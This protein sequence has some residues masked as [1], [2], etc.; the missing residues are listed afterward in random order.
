MTKLPN[1]AIDRE[2][3]RAALFAISVLGILASS[4][5]VYPYDAGHYEGLILAPA[6]L[7]ASGTNPYSL[8]LAT[9][10]PYVVSGYGPVYYLVVGLGIRLF[11]PN[12]WF[13][14]LAA[15]AA[16]LGCIALVGVVAR[17][18]GASRRWAFTASALFA[19]TSPVQAWI[20]L[21]RPDFVALVA[22]LGGL[23]LTL[24]SSRNARPAIGLLAG[25]LLGV[26]LATRQT[27]VGPVVASGLLA[28]RFGGLRSL[29]WLASG[30]LIAGGIPLAMLDATSNGG[31]VAQMWSM[32]SSLPRSAIVFVHHL[33]SL[34]Q[35]PSVWTALAL[36]GL[37]TYR[38]VRSGGRLPTAA[39][40]GPVSLGWLASCASS[41]LTGSIPG[42]NV[43]YFLEPLALACTLA[44]LG[45][46][47]LEPESGRARLGTFVLLVV[48]SSAGFMGARSVRGEIFRWQARPYYDEL[49]AELRRVTPE[50]EAC[51]SLYP[52]LAVAANRRYYVNTMSGYEQSERLRGIL[53]DLF[54][55]RRFAALVWPSADPPTGYRPVRLLHAVPERFHAAH[56]HVRV[57][58][59]E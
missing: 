4:R 42:S 55:R 13:G 8:E 33:S 39:L 2:P 16:A 35:S 30:A 56:L 53:R 50:S 7:M 37:H 10:P 23:A 22:A 14:R 29:G 58:P 45:L 26:A 12:L 17:Q 49:V 44:A 32:P 27:V 18:C 34:A 6:A 15:I 9:G 5:L 47:S 57:S 52:E 31:L 43:N 51:Y 19:S 54:A 59:P 20:G 46:E 40:S 11:G 38:V 28:V 21:Q 25:A 48:V 41:A 36:A 1:I 3:Y 24:D